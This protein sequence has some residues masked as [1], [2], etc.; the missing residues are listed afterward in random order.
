MGDVVTP[1][2]GWPYQSLVFSPNGAL[3]GDE[4]F[5]AI[6]Q[7]VSGL[8]S[9]L[10]ARITALEAAAPYR[11]RS[12]VSIAAAS[13]SFTGIPA[14]LRSLTLYARAR[15]QSGGALSLS[16]RVNN[17]SSANYTT[18]EF[19]AT[20]AAD[21][22]PVSAT[23]QTFGLCGLIIGNNAANEFAASVATWAAWEA[24]TSLK[25]TNTFVA[26]GFNTGTLQNFSRAGGSVYHVASPYTRLDVFCGT[27]GALFDVGSAFYLVG[28]RV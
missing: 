5:N 23:A 24:P 21:S 8:D 2:Y 25:L 12:V 27:G 15:A 6:E 26:H 28:D 7:T 16:F 11:D 22:T 13:V 14:G 17:D 10:A 3:L 1:I 20:N 19:G 4:G 18:H 9:T